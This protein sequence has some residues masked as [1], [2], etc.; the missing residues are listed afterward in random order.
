MLLRSPAWSV[1]C[2]GPVSAASWSP[3][4]LR[5]YS[6]SVACSGDQTC[7][8]AR[9]DAGRQ[10]CGSRGVRHRSLP[11]P[12]GRIR[13]L[14]G[15]D[16]GR[17]G[18]VRGPGRGPG[19]LGVNRTLRRR[20][21]LQGHAGARHNWRRPGQRRQARTARG[22]GLIPRADSTTA[23][24]VSAHRSTAIRPLPCAAAHP[25]RGRRSLPVRQRG[26]GAAAAPCWSASP[27]SR[28]GGRH[29]VRLKSASNS[30][31]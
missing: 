26:G 11:H 22:R 31:Q 8:A 2:G 21:A 6:S 25:P 1:W 27:A 30:R 19:I 28:R 24:G 13:G 16:G 9:A 20:P 5:R 3:S 14:G 15:R 29:R 7:G 18:A 10:C 17:A 4:A 12:T 23:A